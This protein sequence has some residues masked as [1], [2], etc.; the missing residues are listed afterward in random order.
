MK[1]NYVNIA[2]NAAVCFYYYYLSFVDNLKFVM[3]K[4][5]FYLNYCDLSICK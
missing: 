3:W 2:L 4:L 1:L 5:F